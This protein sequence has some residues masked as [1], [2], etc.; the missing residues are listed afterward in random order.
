M[1]GDLLAHVEILHDILQFFDRAEAQRIQEQVG[2]LVGVLH[3]NGKFVVFFR[4]FA[5]GDRVLVSH[6]IRLDHLRESTHAA[7]GVC[8]QRGH[9]ALL[10]VLAGTGMD[11]RESIRGVDR[12]DHGS[13]GVEIL[14]HADVVLIFL[15]MRVQIIHEALEVIV[16][17]RVRKGRYILLLDQVI[18]LCFQLPVGLHGQ[19]SAGQVPCFRID[20]QRVAVHGLFLD[21][22]DVILESGGERQDQ[23]D[24]DDTD[25]PRK[26]GQESPSLLGHKVVQAQPEG[27]RKAHGSLSEVLVNCGL[28]AVDLQG[29]GV[30]RDLPVLKTDNAVG[31][32]LGEFRVVGDHDD[33]A[34]VGH[35]LEKVHDLNRCL[36]VQSSGGLV[37]QEDLGIVYQGARDGYA[38]HLS[39]GHLVGLL[40]GLLPEA[41]FFQGVQSHLPA[42]VS[43]DA[44]DRQCQ[45]DVLQDSLVGDQVVGLEDKADRVVAVGVP[46]AVLV[47]F[48]RYAVDDQIAG[49][50]AVQSAYD[51]EEGGLARAARPEDRDELVVPQ[52]ERDVIEGDLL[53]PSGIVFLP[54]ILKL[55]HVASAC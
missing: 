24:T 12:V 49:V 37:G 27:G 5:V 26:G 21:L 47:F 14:D 34:V 45:L 15:R 36:G 39:A 30:I 3:G 42:L 17:D 28:L 25:G 18:A 33:Q 4:P 41:D 6:A 7:A 44:A 22:V 9:H 35:F 48:G 2:D 13:D 23:R 32:L 16:G 51:I 38:L 53:V 46:V 43:G 50:V 52:V 11:L 10:L 29:I 54:Y 20:S 31:V 55:Q 19:N 1:H 40:V 8:H